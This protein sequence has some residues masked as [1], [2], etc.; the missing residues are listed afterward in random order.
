MP[1]AET[2][3]PM[4]LSAYGADKLCCEAQAR[5]AARSYGLPSLGLRFFNVYGPRQDPA[6]PYSGVIS[7]FARSLLARSPLTIFGDGLQTRDFVFVGDVVAC[8]LAAVGKASMQAD[9]LNV[10]TGRGTTVSQLAAAVMSAAGASVPVMYSEARVG[11]IRLSVGS[12][13]RA[14]A[15]LGRENRTPLHVGLRRTLEW[16]CEVDHNHSL[17]PDI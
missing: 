7:I 5:T 17:R 16:L 13:V 6:S 11:D 8:L 14:V 2:A 9:V 15:E 3:S 1:I 4:P 12:P 10:C